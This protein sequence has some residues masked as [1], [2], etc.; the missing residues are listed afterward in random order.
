MI[1]MP[2]GERSMQDKNDGTRGRLVGLVAQ[3]LGQG[4][5]APIAVDAALNELGMTSIKMVNLM[6]AVEAEFSLA[7]PQSDI[8]PQNFRS[9]AS[10]E[11]LVHRLMPR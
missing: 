8:T 11:A 5:Q 9:I 1:A 10:I 2:A 3:I 7:I 4:A 6:L